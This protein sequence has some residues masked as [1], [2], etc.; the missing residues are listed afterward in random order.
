MHKFSD[1]EEE[2]SFEEIKEKKKQ[3]NTICGVTFIQSC[4]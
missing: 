3:Y 2:D 1:D 4:R